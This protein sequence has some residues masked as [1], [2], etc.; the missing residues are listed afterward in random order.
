MPVTPQ[1]KLPSLCT[2]WAIL[3]TIYSIL[4]TSFTRVT[5]KLI[6]I[7]YK[8]K[9]R[10]CLLR[11]RISDASLILLLHAW[12]RLWVISFSVLSHVTSHE[13]VW[14]GGNATQLY[15]GYAV[16]KS[17]SVHRLS[18]LMLFLGFLSTSRQFQ[19]SSS[20]M[21]WTFDFKSFII[22]HS[23]LYSLDTLT[24]LSK[25]D[26]HVAYFCCR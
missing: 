1:Y 22:H 17:P 23:V 6:T 26:Q 7:L 11:N 9:H 13:A 18:W 2:L 21:A 15:S 4:N 5:C 19:G 14:C 20:V 12:V 8:C 16:F 3:C 10:S 24:D 25:P